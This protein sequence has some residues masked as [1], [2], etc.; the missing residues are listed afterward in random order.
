MSGYI[1]LKIIIIFNVIIVMSLISYSLFLKK[2]KKYL[3]SIIKLA[4]IPFIIQTVLII[5]LNSKEFNFH[6]TIIAE[7]VYLIYFIYQ[8][9]KTNKMY[10]SK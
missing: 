3:Y 5:G 6:V 9:K 8:V 10:L 7:L 2:N 1:F 4:A